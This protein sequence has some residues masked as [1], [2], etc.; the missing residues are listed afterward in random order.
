[1]NKILYC[2]SAFAALL[3][4]ISVCCG[5]GYPKVALA[6]DYGDPTVIRD[7]K[8]YYMTHS[9]FS[10]AP[11]LLIW[12]STDLL[13]WEPVCR[14]LNYVPANVYAPDMVKYQGKYYIYFPA[15]GKNY[16]I[17]ANK[18]TGPWSKPIDLKIAGRI[19]PGHAV[20]EDEKRYLFLSGGNRVGLTDDGLSNDGTPMKVVYTGW[21][22]PKEWKTE[23]KWLESPKI[24]KHG[25]YFYLT[26]A[27]GG[28]AGPPTSHM[29]VSA[30]SKSIN[31][32]WENSPY[33]PIVHT[34]SAD[35]PW[36][37]KGHGTIIDDVN[38]NWWIIYHAYKNGF[39]T[40]GR[41]NLV[42]PIEWTK[43]GWF[44]L[45]KKPKKALVSQIKHTGLRLSD[46]F[47]GNDLGLQWAVWQQGTATG[48]VI[49]DHSIFIEGK[50]DGP[51]NSRRL[52]CIPADTSY[53]AEV[54]VQPEQRCSGGLL[55]SY[56][57]KA[58]RG[59]VANATTF[60]VY[61]TAR[62]Y[63]EFPRKHN[64]PFKLRIDN[65]QEHCTFSVSDDGRNWKVL[66]E[67]I[68]V[69]G[70]QHNNYKG[71]L[72]LKIALAAVGQGQVKFNDFKYQ[73]IIAP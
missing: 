28:T 4:S 40:L 51:A 21:D 69:S 38:G 50:G 68:I 60:L 53:R 66:A 29:V 15:S 67:N 73:P 62:T 36:W 23:G 19:D 43:D 71:F 2:F 42:E 49:K 31:G 3:F 72:G 16:V 61:D 34:Y 41:Y 9:A 26:T 11:G 1:M 39:Y 33:N 48:V 63:K 37:S 25:E 59:I 22:F 65:H 7:G 27:E 32:P 24:V 70:L 57:D 30:R 13:H 47:A 8:D 20:G 45:A 18:I 56:N 64:G 14:A 6:G 52:V 54:T 12:H 46:D 58:F 5:Q 55:L 10:N 35:E 17:W 44:K